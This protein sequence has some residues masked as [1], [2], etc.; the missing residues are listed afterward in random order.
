MRFPQSQE[1]LTHLVRGQSVMTNQRA[2]IPRPSNSPSTA[3]KA[4]SITSASRARIV[5][6]RQTVT[7]QTVARNFLSLQ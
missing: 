5:T 6:A 7:Y 3:Y 1:A 2:S 4:A